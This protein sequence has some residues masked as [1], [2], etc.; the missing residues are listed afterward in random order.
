VIK[1]SQADLGGHYK[2]PIG[3]NVLRHFVEDLKR[4]GRKSGGGFYE[5]PEHGKKFLW[6]GLA[7]EYPRLEQQPTL[8][9]VK[10]RLLYIQALETA[11]CFEEGVITSAEEADIGSVLGWG[12]PS[13]TGG[14]LSFIDTVGAAAFVK[15]CQRLVKTYGPRF[16]PTRGLIAKAR[17]GGSF[18]PRT[19]WPAREAE[20][21]V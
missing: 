1:Q 12:F 10:T 2:D 20:G 7:R 3:W 9:E 18:Y 14:T 13:F 17:S 11:R 5:Y 16:K 6:P 4:L 21:R 8:A 19:P 15:G